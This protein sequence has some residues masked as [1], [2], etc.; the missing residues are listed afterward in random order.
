MD[1]VYETV[2][3]S[4]VLEDDERFRAWIDQAIEKKE[5]EA[6]PSY[7][8]EAKKKR[9]ARVKAV[10]GEAKEAEELAKELGV[11]DKLMGSKDGDAKT[12]TKGKAGAKGGKGK[13][14]DGEGALAALILARQQSRG[15]MF[16]KLAEKYGAKP[17]GKG[18]K[19]KAEEPPEIDEDE[20]QRMQ[21]G[22]GK[23]GSSSGGAKKGK[24]RKA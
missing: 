23:G 16:D 22:L 10:R 4:D 12:A 13:R 5:V 21:A 2:M 17:K 7:T 18:S 19:R 14:N 24:K 9:A 20:F 1:G 3:L 11:Y 6:Y 8:K 15:D